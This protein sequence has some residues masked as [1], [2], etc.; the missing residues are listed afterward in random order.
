MINVLYQR[1]A[2]DRKWSAV[3]RGA[4]LLKKL[5]DSLAPGITTLLV[6][7]KVVRCFARTCYFIQPFFFGGGGWGVRRYFSSVFLRWLIKQ[8]ILLLLFKVTIGVFGHEEKV[9][10][11]P[12]TPAAIQVVLF[13][14][15]QVL[16]QNRYHENQ[17]SHALTT[18]VALF[19]VSR[20]RSKQAF[21]N[22]QRKKIEICNNQASKQRK[23]NQQKILAILP[24]LLCKTKVLVSQVSFYQRKRITDSNANHVHFTK[25][26]YKTNAL[27]CSLMAVSLSFLNRKSCIRSV[28]LMTSG[29][30][31]F[32]KRS[33]NQC[34]IL[35]TFSPRDSSYSCDSAW[36]VSSI[37]GTCI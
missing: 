8:L 18:S 10:Y 9:I 36:A 5:V 28:L 4:A 11:E 1:A 35:K 29:R 2:Y 13:S 32:N 15:V 21:A 23:R 33:E 12:L 31:S 25:D 37:C 24:I 22:V 30:Q 16:A 17:H 20:T 6:S 19:L 27:S 3:R 26:C 14:K 7:G 34:V